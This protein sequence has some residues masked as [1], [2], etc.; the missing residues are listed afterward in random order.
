[1]ATG[2]VIMSGNNVQLCLDLG[3]KEGESV[4]SVLL[5]KSEWADYPWQPSDN[6]NLLWAAGHRAIPSSE[7][8]HSSTQVCSFALFLLP[9]IFFWILR[10]SLWKY[11]SDLLWQ[12]WKAATAD[13]SSTCH[14]PNSPLLIHLITDCLLDAQPAVSHLNS[15][16]SHRGC[17]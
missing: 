15:S 3:S 8:R 16:T 12:Q 14:Q 4:G 11:L 7:T 5:A 2:D 17:W 13:I 9:V 10:S 6:V 1:M